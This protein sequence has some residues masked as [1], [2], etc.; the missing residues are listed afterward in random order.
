LLGSLSSLN[1]KF[2]NHLTKIL[3]NTTATQWSVV[4]HATAERFRDD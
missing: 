2:Y 3:F 4:G 1:A